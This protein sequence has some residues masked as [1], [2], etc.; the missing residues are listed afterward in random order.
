MMSSRSARSSPITCRRLL[1]QG[2]LL[3]PSEGHQRI[4]IEAVALTDH[5]VSRLQTGFA[6]T[7]NARKLEQTQVPL[8]AQLGPLPGAKALN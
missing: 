8:L 7:F 5:H 6:D 4:R 3:T 2:P 1:H